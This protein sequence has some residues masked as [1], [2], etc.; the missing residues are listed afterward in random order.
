MKIEERVKER[1]CEQLGV[2]IS[3]VQSEASFVDNLGADSLDTVELVM[4][5]EVEFN[6]EIPDEIVEKIL[7]VQDAVDYITVN[8]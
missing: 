4:A 8:S 5:F 1:I 3:L 7:T 6:I 2:A